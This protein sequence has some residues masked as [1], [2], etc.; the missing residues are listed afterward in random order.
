MKLCTYICK[1]KRCN[2]FTDFFNWHHILYRQSCVGGNT[3]HDNFTLAIHICLMYCYYQVGIT[4]VFCCLVYG[5]FLCQQSCCLV[6]E[7]QALLGKREK[8]KCF[9]L[10]PYRFLG[11]QSVAQVVEAERCLV[12]FS[13]G[14]EMFTIY[15]GNSWKV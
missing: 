7:V 13:R 12:C 1:R 14:W 15:W 9:L 6:A 4:F 2:D 11:N 10:A 3:F 5:D 8:R